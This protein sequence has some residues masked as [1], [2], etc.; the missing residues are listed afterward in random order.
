MSLFQC[1][2]NFSE[3]RNPDVVAAL[4]DAI[5]SI[6]DARLIDHSADYDH[7][8]C[9]MTILGGPDAI[10]E[11]VLAAAHIAIE[12][13]DLR[14]HSGVHPRIGAIDVV[15]VVPLRGATREQAIDL[16]RTIGAALA[17]TFGLPIYF[18]EWTA[19]PNKRSAL[20]Q[21]RAGGY[22]AFAGRALTGDCAPDLGP[23]AVHPSAGIAIV[24]ARSPLV[25]YN[26]NLGTKRLDIAKHIARLIR[27][28]RGTLPQLTGVRALGL[29]LVT[30]NK[31]QV[32]MNLTRPERTPL[33]AVFAFVREAA[34]EF[35]ITELESE[36]IGAIPQSSLGGEPAE[37]IRWHTY[38]PTQI[39]ET[40]LTS[41]PPPDS[42]FV[43]ERET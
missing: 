13:I 10:R 37:A 43:K 11:S 30:Q 15:P 20:P 4:A 33:P 23:N 2:P 25:A 14:T 26:I 8:R 31:V 7:N 38:Q 27:E 16:S 6:P 34:Q 29:P 12:R 35:G 24:G 1:V 21:L 18:Y 17:E 9:V 41:E 42:L 36:I 5:R 19:P 3:G 22:E 40:W 32:S 28:K 39:L